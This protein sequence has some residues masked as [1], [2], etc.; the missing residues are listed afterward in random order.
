MKAI[1]SKRRNFKKQ[2]CPYPLYSAPFTVGELK[3]ALRK[4]KLGKAAAGFDGIY[5][6]FLKYTGPGT[7]K[8][9]S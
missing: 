3:N 1:K 9:L 6:E 7:R 4:T 8:W 2:L 5:P